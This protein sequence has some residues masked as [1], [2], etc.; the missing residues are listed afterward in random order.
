MSNS[1][2]SILCKGTSGNR[3]QDQLAL[4]AQAFNCDPQDL[5][6]NYQDYQ[7]YL[8]RFPQL[9]AESPYPMAR[10]NFLDFLEEIRLS[11]TEQE[12][13]EHLPSEQVAGGGAAAYQK[14]LEREFPSA[15]ETLPDARS[16]R[17]SVSSSQ[18]VRSQAIQELTPSIQ[19][20]QS[21]QAQP[22]P[23]SLEDEIFEAPPFEKYRIRNWFLTYWPKPNENGTYELYI[24]P[25]GAKAKYYAQQL[26]RCPHTGRIHAHMYIE[27]INL[28]SLST[29]K[30]MFNDNTINCLF[31]KGTQQQAIDYC[32]KED[33][34]LEGYE[35]LIFGTPKLSG[36]RN[37]LDGMTELA[38]RGLTK[39]EL[40]R[41]YGGNAFRHL[42]MIDRVHAVVLGHDK[43]DNELMFRRSR[44]EAINKKHPTNHSILTIHRDI[45]YDQRLPE[46]IDK[47][48]ITTILSYP[49]K[50]PYNCV[51]EE[52]QQQHQRVID[53]FEQDQTVDV[54][55]IIDQLQ[56]D[57]ELKIKS[58]PDNEQED[59]KSNNGSESDKELE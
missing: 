23:P 58:N 46:A 36:Q 18:H 2:S 7:L 13:E 39:F 8:E 47:L 40:L 21:L 29:I 27:F 10:L 45:E 41:L 31:R 53:D 55:L 1:R 44:L 43:H 20:L 30:R 57:K 49:N 35:P 26:E 22:T 15:P 16:L 56:N 32:T 52:L 48:P 12:Q 24:P 28:Q 14:P 9:Q 25:P 59:T 6:P 19:S 34:R 37:D 17:Q 54:E 51:A 5:I 42:G 33:T 11:S 50:Y 3:M 4:A 38:M